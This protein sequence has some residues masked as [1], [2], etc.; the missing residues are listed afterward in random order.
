MVFAFFHY[1]DICIDGAKV[2]VDKIGDV[3]AWIKGVTPNDMNRDYI[4]TQPHTIFFKKSKF[5]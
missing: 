2:L 1:A 3:L 5:T 4:L